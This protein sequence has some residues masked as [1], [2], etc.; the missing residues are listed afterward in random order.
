MQALRAPGAA[1][2]CSS[3]RVPLLQGPRVVVGRPS[4]TRVFAE[5]PKSR[6]TREYREDDDSI[7]VPQRKNADG[8][9]YVDEAAV[10]AAVSWIALLSVLVPVRSAP[11]TRGRGDG[12]GAS[13][14]CAATR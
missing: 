10:R 8:S 12:G 5:E 1:P 7:S 2:C 6:V 13:T 9:I 11:V 3:R 14:R 4:T